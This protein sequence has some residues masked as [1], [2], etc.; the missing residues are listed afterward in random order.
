M[1]DVDGQVVSAEV[2]VQRIEEL[3][4]TIDTAGPP[5]ETVSQIV[6]PSLDSPIRT[7]RIIQ[8]EMH[9]PELGGGGGLRRRASTMAKRIVRKLT[10][11]YVEPRWTVQN[12]LD[13]PRPWNTRR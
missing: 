12:D 3:L 8:R 10:H 9:P 4:A 7:M 11:W 2:L 6:T 13:R 1:L 5:A